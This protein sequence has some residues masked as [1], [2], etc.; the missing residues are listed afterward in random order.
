MKNI[1]NILNNNE[2][3]IIIS[4]FIIVILLITFIPNL[5]NS[6]IK[7]DKLYISEIMVNNTYT[8]EDEDG[9]YSDY[10]E[11]YNGYNYKINLD[12]Y[13]LS[14]SE[15]ETSKWKFPEI[16]INANE[17]LIIF[18]SGKN[19]CNLENKICHTNFKLSSKSETLTLTD[20]THTII[21]K[22]TYPETTNDVSF[23][24]YKRKYTHLE[25]PSPGKINNINNTQ[26]NKITNK[27]LYIN[28]YLS[29]NTRNIYSLDG[30]YHD[31]VELYNNSEEDLELNNI[32][33]T[34]NKKEL[35]KYKLPNITI[36]SKEYLI[37]YL[38]EE[39]KIINT[40]IISN[41]KITSNE[42][43][44]LSNGKKII[45]KIQIVELPENVSYGKL[46]DK[47]YYF[48]KPTPGTINNTKAFSTLGGKNERT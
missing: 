22:F 19:K 23:G 30:Q 25:I 45:D 20:K 21:N 10:I 16:T 29:N 41:F 26:N 27:D 33:L 2:T 31:W 37:I 17:Y 5:D 28:E 6:F 46:E 39:S 15:F 12:G 34:D 4:M 14:D 24:F 40:Q 3:I 43:L 38:G 47:W 11:I 7:A 48:T 35:N 18:A 1:K 8:L 9:D 36:K 44:I 32:Y 13:Y 42:E